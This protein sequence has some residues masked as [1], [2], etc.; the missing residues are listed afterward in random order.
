MFIG[1]KPAISV[2]IVVKDEP[3]ID[4]SLEIL[5]SQCDEMGAECVVVDASEHRLDSIRAK[6]PWVTWFDYKQPV[7][8]KITIAHQ[9]NIAVSTAQA[10]VLLFCEAGGT[11]SS[12]WVHDLS[13]PLL[14]GKLQLVGGP[15]PFTSAYAS[16]FGENL[17]EDGEVLKASATGNI[18]FTRATYDL[19]EGFNEDLDYGSDA[20]FIWKLAVQGIQH[21]CVKSASVGIDGGSARR[22]LK[23]NWLY[24]KAIVPIIKL[25][26]H[27][28]REKFRSNPE[29]WVY[30]ALLL[31]WCGALMAVTRI[32]ILFL[33]P[34]V[35]TL[36]LI[37]KNIKNKHPFRIVF[38]HYVYGAGSIYMLLINKWHERKIS[39]ILIFPRGNDKYTSELMRA[40][41]HDRKLT[42][43]FPRLG[44]SA[45]LNILF[46]PIFSLILKVRGVRIIHI[47]WL[48]SFN[49]HW[50][51]GKVSRLL[52]Q[53]WFK[54]WVISLKICN[55]RI[56]YTVHNL[57]PHEIIFH[58][59]KTTFQFLERYASVLIL[60]NERSFKS[61]SQDYSEKAT[62]LIPEG[63]LNPRTAYSRKSMNELLNV[64]NKS[65]IVLVGNLSP[66]KQVDLLVNQSRHIPNNF[67]LRIAGNAA[68]KNY[69]DLLKKELSH[70]KLQGID[71][72]ICFGRL[73]DNEFG[74]YLSVAHYFC[75]PFKEINNSGSI[76][77]ALCAGI[78]VIVPN[79]AS[80]EWVPDGAR[81]NLTYNSEGHLN[82]KE[83]FQSLGQV[84]VSEYESMRKAALH[85]ASILTWQDVAK[86]HI[87]LY[88]GLINNNE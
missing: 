13:K 48:Y 1:E 78:P 46:M 67:A 14:E 54:L 68:D 53:N 31:M 52:I 34:L 5:K 77:S 71:V 70:A 6:H 81:L 15:M 72:D 23:R 37:L 74:G 85:W 63:P 57:T 4:K 66:Y 82:F 59:D 36:L 21:I 58:N 29:L 32:P 44:P 88:K 20:D 11:P 60:L 80:L 86:Q 62:A 50:S 28:R 65:L 7:G 24:G 83:L 9:R 87:Y 30:P 42:E 61:F 41:N 84:S 55:I 22:E 2:L 47:H 75:V 73:T 35:A 45:T 49:L 40:L 12:K 51:K 8:R 64:H 43:Y 39:P 76:N 17:Q 25:H 3:E 33:A 38:R 79:I 56:V 19:V 26:P 18:G 69:K 27:K 16:S 10:P